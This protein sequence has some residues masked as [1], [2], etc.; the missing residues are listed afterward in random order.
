MA[1]AGDQGKP[2]VAEATEAAE[3]VGKLADAVIQVRDSGWTGAKHILLLHFDAH[4]PHMQMYCTYIC[5]INVIKQKR[6]IAVS[7]AVVHWDLLKRE[8]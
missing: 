3:E 1:S 5:T 6:Y 4:V 7:M 2:F 8:T